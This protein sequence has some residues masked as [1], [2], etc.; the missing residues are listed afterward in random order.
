MITHKS[1]TSPI[2]MLTLTALDGVLASVRLGPP[3]ASAGGGPPYGLAAEDGFEDIER[4]L[5]EYF[6]GT[7]CCF[8]VDTNPL[9]TEF[10]R[11]V[12]EQVACIGY[13]R[14]ASYKELA[15]RLGDAAKAR[16][17]G[18]ALAHNPL[19]LIVPTHRVVGSRG[20]LTGY[21]GG[22][23]AKRYLIELEQA[24][25]TEHLRRTC[26]PADSVPA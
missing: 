19:N 26:L 20:A 6:E 11:R 18:A 17:V 14:T 9:G 2:G 8:T 4:Q 1:V 12:W 13:G 25:Q 7:R 15:V 16:S 21:S 10:Q 3:P 22:V 23:D 5:S 24:P